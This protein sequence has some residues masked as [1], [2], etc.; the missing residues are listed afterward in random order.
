MNP[1]P[2]LPT[3]QEDGEAQLLAINYAFRVDNPLPLSDF[4]DFSEF[5]REAWEVAKSSQ[6]ETGF[7]F[8]Y[9]WKSDLGSVLTQ[10]QSAK[11]TADDSEDDLLPGYDD[12]NFTLP[13]KHQSQQE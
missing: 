8:L 7:N 4:Y 13:T 9:S 11:F 2:F 1:Y 3:P 12:F 6:D 5:A 10:V